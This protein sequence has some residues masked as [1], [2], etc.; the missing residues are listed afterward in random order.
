MVVHIM[1]DSVSYLNKPNILS[2]YWET[3]I[4]NTFRK[5]IDKAELN[6]SIS[7]QMS[8]EYYTRY[9]RHFIPF[10]NPIDI[11]EWR[12]YIKSNWAFSDE[13]KIIYTG[14]LAEPN[15]HSLFTFSQAIE[16]IRNSGINITLHIFSI[17]NAE[18]FS[19]KT[20]K[21]TSIVY[22]QP[23][24]PSEIPE[25]L[26]K[27]DLALLPLDFTTRGIRY[28]RFS[29]STKT[30]EYMI[31]GVPV[32]LFA[33]QNVALTS[34]AVKHNCMY[35]VSDNHVDILVSSI[36]NLLS[37][38]KQRAEIA[39]NAIQQAMDDADANKVRAEFK[40][41]IRSVLVS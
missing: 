41:A 9:G 29:I 7:D 4:S 24:K 20:D 34:Y 5:L 3:Y 11:N 22:H 31:S 40:K 15:I 14:R 21:M 10:R 27:F 36:K 28:A 6:L 38:E 39:N 30:S 18:V 13:I 19:R 23:V 32:V 16:N 35:S 33:P 8:A 17:D 25:L 26:S 37:N 2:S 1:D 12:P